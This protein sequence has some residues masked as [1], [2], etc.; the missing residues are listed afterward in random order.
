MK[1]IKKKGEF[2]MWW[3]VIGAVLVLVVITILLLIFKGGAEK[4]ESGFMGCLSKGGSCKTLEACSDEGGTISE[5]F[6][7]EEK[8]GETQYCCFIAKES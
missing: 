8:D 5:T 7:C 3:I 1:S 6:R 2:D 4:G